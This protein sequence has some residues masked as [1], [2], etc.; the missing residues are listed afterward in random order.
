[1]TWS[2]VSKCLQ[3]VLKGRKRTATSLS[4]LHNTQ[5][6]F[7]VYAFAIE[8]K[9]RKPCVFQGFTR[10]VNVHGLFGYILTRIEIS[11]II[12][13]KK[14]IKMV[15]FD[16]L[17]LQPPSYV[18]VLDGLP[19]LGCGGYFSNK[20]TARDV[21]QVIQMIQSSTFIMVLVQQG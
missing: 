21:R 15:I 4:F 2:R 16:I 1:M 11:Q 13:K 6:S 8:Q 17:G 19:Y 7:S 14:Q 18:M 12:Q 9:Y 5:A 20:I 10:A 3:R